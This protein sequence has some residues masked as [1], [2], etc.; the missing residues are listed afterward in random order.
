MR[1]ARLVIREAIEIVYV[2]LACLPPS[3]RTEQLGTW[4]HDCLRDA[5]QWS[6]SPPS[7]R[8]RDVLMKR[9]LALYVEV[10]KLERH[11]RFTS[12]KWLLCEP[13]N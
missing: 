11:A 13:A 3:E 5:E 8:E 7:N 10:K 4:V 9:V 12:V 1:T 2:H 6:A